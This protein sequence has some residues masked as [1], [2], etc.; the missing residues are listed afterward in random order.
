M[1]A[2][3]AWF[4]FENFPMFYIFM[5]SPQIIL[6][7]LVIMES[8][9]K[10]KHVLLPLAIFCK[11]CHEYNITFKNEMQTSLFLLC[12]RKVLNGWH[13][14]NILIGDTNC[15]FPLSFSLGF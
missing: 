3:D 11:Y 14:Q 6:L 9:G 13:L 12:D 4:T 5:F 8:C 10:L 7:T 2:K 1:K 15:L